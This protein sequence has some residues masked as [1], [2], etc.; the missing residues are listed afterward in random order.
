MYGLNWT[1]ILFQSTSQMLSQL[2]SSHSPWHP[3]DLRV[4]RIQISLCPLQAGRPWA[5]HLPLWSSVSLGKKVLMPSVQNWEDSKDEGSP[6]CRGKK[7]IFNPVL[8]WGD[9]YM[10][11]HGRLPHPSI[12]G[13]PPRL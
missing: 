5:D 8:L 1:S 7:G 3:R 13:K 4:P 12:P 11:T 6:V 10:F 9:K 2:W